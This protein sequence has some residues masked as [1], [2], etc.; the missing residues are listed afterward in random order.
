VLADKTGS[1]WLALLLLLPELQVFG[2]EALFLK[3]ASLTFLDS[4]LR[5]FAIIKIT[6]FCISHRAL[7]YQ[8]FLHLQGERISHTGYDFCVLC[9]LLYCREDGGNI[10]P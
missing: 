1:E 6:A 3:E 9:G 2:P 7:W 4:P 10:F 5:N 8:Y